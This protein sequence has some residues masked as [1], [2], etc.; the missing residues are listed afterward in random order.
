[1]E[2]GLWSLDKTT[3][4]WWRADP[5]ARLAGLRVFY[6]TLTGGD[7]WTVY[8]PQPDWRTPIEDVLWYR[9]FDT[10]KEAIEAVDT[11]IAENP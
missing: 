10:A 1:M 4:V 8:W 3:G 11:H 6:A 5:P 9:R 2:L 7:A